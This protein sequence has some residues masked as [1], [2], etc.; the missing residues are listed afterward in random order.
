MFNRLENFLEQFPTNATS[1]S[2]ATDEVYDLARTSRE[3]LDEY[4]D[5]KVEAVDFATLDTPAKW[6]SVCREAIW[7]NYDL[8]RPHTQLLFHDYFT[9]RY[10][11]KN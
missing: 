8:M 5:V 6:N 1:W 3:F 9:E 4:D 7:R 11:V 2:Q 10:G